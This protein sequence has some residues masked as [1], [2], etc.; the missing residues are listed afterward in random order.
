MGLSTP[1]WRCCV[2]TLLGLYDSNKVPRNMGKM[3][4]TRTRPEAVNPLLPKLL[5]ILQL[6]RSDTY[7]DSFF[8]MIPMRADPKFGG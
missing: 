7:N 5:K 6:H 3:T 8:G 4:T 1:S 2:Y